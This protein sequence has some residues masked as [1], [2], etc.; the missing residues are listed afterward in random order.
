MGGQWDAYSSSTC[1][2]FFHNMSG[3]L[4]RLVWE[5]KKENRLGRETFEPLEERG[6]WK[7]IFSLFKRHKALES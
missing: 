7:R 1:F 5:A 6:D 4:S 3:N 2:E